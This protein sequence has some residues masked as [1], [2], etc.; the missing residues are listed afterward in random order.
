ML[1]VLIK[2]VL[3]AAIVAGV[4]FQARTAHAAVNAYLSFTDNQTKAAVCA[5]ESLS[6]AHPKTIELSDF[7]FGF[8][9]TLNLGSQSGGA[10]A[11]KAT[12]STFAFTKKL[13]AASTCIAGYLMQGRTLGATL[14]LS[15][16][17]GGPGASPD[18]LVV[19]FK[20]AAFKSQTWSRDETA[21]A[22]EKV[23]FEFGAEQ[24][25]YFSQRSDGSLNTPP[26]TETWNRLNNNDVLP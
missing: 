19:T 15:K 25:K 6:P 3:T 8:S 9:Q 12:F 26:S 13:D 7:T 20:L 2:L 22:L 16:A 14:Y 24:I 17:A 23:E 18:F 11:G 4:A 10:G 21:G 5:G 1:K